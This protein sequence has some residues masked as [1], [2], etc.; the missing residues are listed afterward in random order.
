MPTESKS[1]NRQ[2]REVQIRDG[3]IAPTIMGV[4]HTLMRGTHTHN[5]TVCGVSGVR[6]DPENG[7]AILAVCDGKFIRIRVTPA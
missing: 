6:F 5:G 1:K 3:H 7:D 2:K 4:A